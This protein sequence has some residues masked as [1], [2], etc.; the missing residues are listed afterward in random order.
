MAWQHGSAH[1]QG[2]MVAYQSNE[3]LGTCE[4]WHAARR[5][6]PQ[7]NYL[8]TCSYIIAGDAARS[9]AH[10]FTREGEAASRAPHRREGEGENEA[11]CGASCHAISAA[12]PRIRFLPLQ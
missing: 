2:D 8:Y 11:R 9:S 4:N 1:K 12:A 3:R 6:A 10:H 5:N 7:R